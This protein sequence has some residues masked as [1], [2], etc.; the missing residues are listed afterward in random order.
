MFGPKAT[1][2][3]TV[4]PTPDCAVLDLDAE[5]ISSSESDRSND[6]SVYL[7]RQHS[8]PRHGPDQGSPCSS[9][10]ARLQQKLA[11]DL[12]TTKSMS[13]SASGLSRKQARQLQIGLRALATTWDGESTKAGSGY[14]L[15]WWKGI[16]FPANQDRIRRR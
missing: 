1:P 2:A 7:V 10:C 8:A 4:W 16:I 13:P 11:G 3:S 12:D 6:E 9:I 5:P 14:L 15:G